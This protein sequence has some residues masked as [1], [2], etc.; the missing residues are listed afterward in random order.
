MLVLSRLENSGSENI[1]Y[2]CTWPKHKL[3][4]CASLFVIVYSAKEI[5]GSYSLIRVIVFNKSKP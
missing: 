2:G 3:T 1:V 5:V 4:T